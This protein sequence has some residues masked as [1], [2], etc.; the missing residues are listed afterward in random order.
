MKHKS[1]RIFCRLLLSFERCVQ[2]ASILM[3]I[4]DNHLIKE[5][6]ELI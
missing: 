1:L 4:V 6:S 3:S 5:D 2:Q